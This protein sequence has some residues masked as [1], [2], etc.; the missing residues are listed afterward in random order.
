MTREDFPRIFVDQKPRF[1][2]AFD[3]IIIVATFGASADT[4]ADCFPSVVVT[5]VFARFDGD[6][7]M[8]D[9]V[10]DGIEDFFFGIEVAGLHHRSQES[11]E[12][13]PELGLL[14]LDVGRIRPHVH[15]PVAADAG[16]SCYL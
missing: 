8:S 6:E 13:D 2:G 12:L 14:T 15:C 11:A 4:V 7:G 5:T 10:K 16:D 9:F 1:G 3:L